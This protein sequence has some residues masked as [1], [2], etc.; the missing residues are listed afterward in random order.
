MVSKTFKLILGLSLLVS[1]AATAQ[2]AGSNVYMGGGHSVY[3]SS[4]IPTKKMGQQ[5]EFWNNNYSFPAKPRNMWEVGVSTGIFTVSGDVSPTVLTAP[6]FSVHVRKSFGYIFS[7]RLQYLNTVGKGQNWKMSQ[8]FAEND[9]WI[10][11]GY[12]APYRR[13]NAAGVVLE[14]AITVNPTTGATITLPVSNSDVVYYNYKTK[15]QDL[16]LQGIFTINNIRFHKNKTGI[17]IYG[18][19]GIGATFYNTRVN[20]LNDQ[21]NATGGNYATAFRTIFNK[22]SAG[23]LYSKR[24]EI[25]KELKAAMDDT[26]ESEA[27]SHR[28]QGNVVN[29]VGVRPGKTKN[30]MKPS[31]TVL[32][33]VAFKLGR[34]INLAIE[35]RWTFIKDDLLDGQRWQEQ[36]FGNP[37]QTRDFDS[38][39]YASV[40]LNFNLG[41]KSVEPLYWLNPMDYAYSELNNPRH[42]KM[43]KSECDDVDGDGVCD[44]LDKEPNTPAGCPVDTHGVT[45]D[46]DGDG[47]PDCKDKQLI[48]PTECQPVDADGV[49][50]CPVKCCDNPV[51]GGTPGCPTDYPSVSFKGSACALG[52]DAKS[53][54]NAVASKMK[55]NPTCN[56]SMMGHPGTSKK[57]QANANCRL[58]AAKKYLVENGGISADRIS[59]SAEVGDG[60]NENTIDITS[61]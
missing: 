22:Y 36:S 39:N 28:F 45:L 20:A 25:R 17:I 13:A 34:R 29:S 46:T 11:N 24:K 59:T 57:A 18:G 5:N 43:P 55:A 15:V 61:N 31:G 14:Q 49:G 50:K 16:G 47:V 12:F 21:G 9:A 26:Y 27:E 30:T 23:D 19:G 10:T 38:Y 6:N 32:L 3:D 60:S 35:D 40:G 2:N 51:A 4:V 42:L 33:G 1:V 48:T 54:L 41:G 8:N 52:A 37:V 56:I 7:L 44:F 58:D 53:L